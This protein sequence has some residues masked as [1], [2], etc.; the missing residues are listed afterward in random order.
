MTNNDFN[1]ETLCPCVV[2][3]YV[4]FPLTSCMLVSNHQPHD[5]LLNG[6]FMHRS[7]KTPK[8]RVT[9]LCDGNSHV[10]G[11]FPHKMPVPR[12]MFPFY[13]VIVHF[14]A[15]NLNDGWFV[16]LH[17]KNTFFMLFIFLFVYAF[18]YVLI[19]YNARMTWFMLH[20][21][22]VSNSVLIFAKHLCTLIFHRLQWLSC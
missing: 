3:C 22:H 9:G 16:S 14:W 21:F 8:L 10:T 13:D 5:C 20:Y 11:D 12:K 15:F 19:S 6:L 18:T 2:W 17:N 7:K 4:F 1:S